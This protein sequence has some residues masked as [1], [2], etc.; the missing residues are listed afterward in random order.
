MSLS[1]AIL[2]LVTVRAL[3]G[4]TLAEAR[5]FNSDI[6]PLD[7]RMTKDPQ[8]VIVV[9]T[10]DDQSEGVGRSFMEFQSRTVELVIEMAI[11]GAAPATGVTAD[12]QPVIVSVGETDAGMEFML[13][14]LERQITT[15]LIAAEGSWPEM[16]RRFC[17]GITRRVSRRGGS[18]DSGQRYAAR[19][20][21]L[22]C[23][24]L[25]E[26]PKGV[27]H[28]AGTAWG[29]L[30]DAVAADVA[31]APLAPILRA[32]FGGE[33]AT[34]AQQAAR[35]FGLN[36]DVDIA[37]GGVFGVVE[38]PEVSEVGLEPPPV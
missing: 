18:A 31:L 6:D 33:P 13:D 21:A 16:W 25:I 22:T 36:P 15:A 7:A 27:V 1:R 20:L 12:D 19:Q 26:P 8:P 10:D 14:L 24:T 38:T 2:R 28:G 34:V 5:V 17:T 32:E 29:D 30:I 35:V 37:L 4:Q 23:T 9:F 11:A 3:S